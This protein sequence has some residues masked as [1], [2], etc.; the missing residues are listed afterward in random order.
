MLD[1]IFTC[2]FGMN[3]YQSVCY[4]LEH[5]NRYEIDRNI[6]A[7]SDK[8][9]YAGF[10]SDSLRMFTI[11]CCRACV[12][13]LWAGVQKWCVVHWCLIT[14]TPTLYLEGRESL[15]RSV[16]EEFLLHIMTHNDAEWPHILYAAQ[17]R[18]ISLDQTSYRDYLLTRHVSC[19]KL[20]NSPKYK[21]TKNKNH[22][23]SLTFTGIQ[24]CR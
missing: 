21:S 8:N 5:K 18:L 13:Q 22:I 6:S 24:S 7:S 3:E 23:I 11:F 16:S 9:K 1:E 2:I 14:W 20:H 17:S 15:H 4:Q 12:L 10:I 19:I